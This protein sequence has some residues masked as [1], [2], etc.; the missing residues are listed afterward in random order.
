M[1]GRLAGEDSAGSESVVGRLGWALEAPLPPSGVRVRVVV[2]DGGVVAAWEAP[3]LG[4]AVEE[5]VEIPPGGA[6]L[7]FEGVWEDFLPGPRA[8]RVGIFWDG[9]KAGEFEAWGRDER[10]EA[11]WKLPGAVRLRELAGSGR[12][13][14]ERRVG[15]VAGEEE[16][17][18]RG[19]V[20]AEE[21]G[22]GNA[23]DEGRA[24]YAPQDA[25]MG[26]EGPQEG[27]DEEAD[28]E[29]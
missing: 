15:T 20:E 8:V 16:G 24:G 28:W 27:W 11:Q 2:P 17:A 5:E 9:V 6:E 25:V 29:P 1:E 18:M 21:G 22:W 4:E 23:G 14:G 19:A 13:M 10:L 3:G 12:V 26:A 7:I